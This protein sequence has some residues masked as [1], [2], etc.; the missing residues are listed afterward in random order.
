VWSVEAYR[1]LAEYDWQA[2]KSFG[3]FDKPHIGNQSSGAAREL[4]IVLRREL[5]YKANPF[6]ILYRP[7]WA[8]R[9][10]VPPAGASWKSSCGFFAAG[11]SNGGGV[12][13]E[14][15]SCTFETRG[16]IAGD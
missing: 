6:S 4:G 16:S 9:G 2:V 15:E 3:R 5:S 8:I 10:A 7:S 14:E 11:A 1:L 13:C 12:I